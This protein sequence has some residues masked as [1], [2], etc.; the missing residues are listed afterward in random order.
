[1]PSAAVETSTSMLQAHIL[2]LKCCMYTQTR[3]DDM[4]CS[5]EIHSL[6][7]TLSRF[8]ILHEDQSRSKLKNRNAQ[9]RLDCISNSAWVTW[10]VSEG[11]LGY[12]VMAREV[13]GHNTSC[14][15]TSSPCNIPDLKC[16][17][18]YDFHVTA[19]NKHCRSNHS[20]F[21]LETGPCA[22]TS[23]TAVT[24]CNSD[25]ILAEWEMKENTPLYLVT[26]E[27]HDQTLISC[28]SSSNS[29][30]LPD[31]SCG[32][33]YSIIVSTSSDKC[34]SLRSPPK[35]IKT[36]PCVPDNVTVEATCEE[37]GAAVTWG[38]SPVATSYQLTA[39]GKDGHVASCN[40]SV[41]NCT[42]G[43]LHCGQTYNLSI[44]ASGDNCTSKP[45]TSSFRTVPCEPSG[46]AVDIDCETHSAM[47]SWGASEGAVEYFGCARSTDGD[48]LYCDSTV[49]SCKIEGLGCGDIYNFSVEASN[50]VCNSS[51]SAPL[52][53]G[54]APCAPTVLNV[55][56]QRI[57]QAHWAMM[58]WDNV[59]CSD[60]EYLME[61]TGRIQN[62]PQ[63]LMQVSSYWLPRAYFE[64]PIPCST[65]YNFT[66]R[67]RNS[68]GAS[69]PSGAFTGVTVPCAPQHVKYTG[70]SVSAVLS[71]DASVFAV[72]YAVY[73]VSGEARV[74]LCNTTG[75]S[76]QMTSFDP[77]ATEVTASNAE[78]ESIPNRDI[79]GPVG[80]RRRRDLQAS[81]I[82]AH[83]DNN[84]EIPKVL[85]VT[86]SGVS[87]YVKWM[88]VK[89]ATEYTVVIVEKQQTNQPPRM[90]TVEGHF[91][92][93]TDLKPWTTYC[94]RLAAQN[95]ISQSTYS[96]PMCR[97]TGA[98]Q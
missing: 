18:H 41:N 46:L 83:S 60:V 81:G 39:T 53:A 93:E 37:N 89:N 4:I 22:L 35:K 20:T 13:G 74:E 85:N 27:G 34:S 86:V 87:L 97:I 73:N 48:A 91:F 1:M 3:I 62:N 40:S 88:T 7:H 57:G 72:R 95:T 49:T 45:N 69:E 75:L 77:N 28:N 31:I 79:T 78:G 32:M 94:F 61:T 55:R 52:W 11:A 36:A 29:C 70:D 2:F 84:L 51:F 64:F 71:W 58:S 24:Q 10:D 14:T 12:D 54:A 68:A 43:D 82:Y 59:N 56:M 92:N 66:V 25:T 80:A 98:S 65:A 15:T 5:S 47:L 63:T 23:I 19:V 21:E 76:C 26:A 17:T 44:T 8:Q 16:G 9:G 90:R 42:L 50:G 96:R 6:K 38:R 30:V 67:S 33:H